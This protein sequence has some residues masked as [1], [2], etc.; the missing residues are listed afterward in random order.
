MA[1]EDLLDNLVLEDFQVFR[2]LSAWMG[3]L[4]RTAQKAIWVLVV[5]KE[6]QVNL[7]QKERRVYVVTILTGNV[8]LSTPVLEDRPHRVSL[9]HRDHR[10]LLDPQGLQEV[11]ALMA[12]MGPLV[13]PENPGNLERT[14]ECYQG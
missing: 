3:N 2:V 14:Q 5:L 11:L 6:F 12:L 10:G 8:V 1:H 13:N 7:V 9:E 4:G